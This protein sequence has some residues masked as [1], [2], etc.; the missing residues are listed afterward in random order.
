MAQDKQR[1]NGRV[2]GDEGAERA[3]MGAVLVRPAVLDEMAL[4]PAAIYSPALQTIYATCR[5][6]HDSGGAVD[7]ATVADALRRDGLL[8]IV[9]GPDV[10]NDLMVDAPATTGAPVASWVGIIERYAR[11][12]RIRDLAGDV[13]AA[14]DAHTDPGPAVDRLAAEAAAPGSAEG[15]WEPEDLS[16][17]LDG[18]DFGPVPTLFERNDG[19]ALLYPGR[20]HAFLGESEAGKGWFALMG[21]CQVIRNGGTVLYVDFE[22]DS[23]GVV[24]RLLLLGLSPQQIAT[25]FFYVRAVEAVD[26]GARGA[27]VA[28]ARSVGAA[29]V[30]IDGITEAMVSAGLSMLENDDV[31]KFY[32]TLP[33]PLAGTGAAVVM[34][35]HLPK[36]PQG[37]GAIGAQHKR[38]G[39]DGASYRLEVTRPFGEGREGSVQVRVDKDRPGK[40]RSYALQGR[41]VGQMV[42]RPDPDGGVDVFLAPIRP[43][44]ISREENKALTMT[45]AEGIMRILKSTPGRRY[46]GNALIIEARSRAKQGRTKI[47]GSDRDV[48]ATLQELA[49]QKGSG[50]VES[51]GP[52]GP[53]YAWWGAEV[54]EAEVLSAAEAEAT[55]EAEAEAARGFDAGIWDEGDPFDPPGSFRP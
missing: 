29:V 15:P 50:V 22:D 21:C 27:L 38:A 17:V 10:L 26:M 32:A 12:R 45:P 19:R 42:V 4:E 14:L 5:S 46:S 54:V 24:S 36:D 39:I 55:A 44:E 49:R 13:V 47:K 43:G 35:D 41:T 33:R 8:D 30:V 6:L 34:I 51:K 53:E 28:V 23:A 9:G 31:A 18:S 25:G 37:K 3:L 11:E 7:T 16:A 48:R 2:Y 20:V 40:V 1:S 52:R